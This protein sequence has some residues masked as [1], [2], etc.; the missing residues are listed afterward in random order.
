VK[1]LLFLGRLRALGPVKLSGYDYPN[2]FKAENLAAGYNAAEEN[3][4]A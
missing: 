1:K 3:F 4:N 2:S